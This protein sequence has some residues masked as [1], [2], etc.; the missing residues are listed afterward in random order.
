MIF[1]IIR[2]L[3]V[4]NCFYVF[5]HRLKL[6]FRIYSFLNPIYSCPV[7]DMVL[8]DILP[9][10]VIEEWF[11]QAN[12]LCV[13]EADK[14]LRGFLD[15]FGKDYKFVGSPP[16][17]FCNPFE[18]VDFQ[19]SSK[20]WE[21]FNLFADQ[22]IKLV[23]ESSRWSWAPIFARA[24]RLTGEKKYS[25]GLNRF[26][27]SWCEENPFNSGLNWTCGQEVAIRLLHAMQ[28][29][30]ILDAPKSSP[31]RTKSRKEFVH[32]H[33]KRILVTH[34]YAIAQANNHWL[35]EAAGLFIGG[36]WLNEKKYK[37]LGRNS[38]E[39]CIN[40]LIMK[41]GTFSQYSIN[42]H[43]FVLDTLCL[44]EIWRRILKLDKFSEMFYKNC[45]N[46]VRWLDEFVDPLTGQT[47]NIGA[48]DGTYC[49][50]FHS[51]SYTNFRPTLR[52]A[53]TIFNVE[54]SLKKGIWDEPLFWLNLNQR[55][56][57]KNEKYSIRSDKD[58]KIFPEGGYVKICPNLK[59]WAYLKIPIYKFR[60]IHADPL[61]FDLWSNGKNILRDGG[62][63][64]YNA[65]F[66]DLNYFQGVSSHNTVQFN[67][68]EPMKKIGR[69]LWGDWLSSDFL[70]IQS[71]S[72]S[73]FS[74]QFIIS[75][76]YSCNLGKHIR[77]IEYN[78][79][80]TVW[81]IRDSISNFSGYATLRW[82]LIPA[83]WEQEN[84]QIKSL[85]GSIKINTF[86]NKCSI[87]LKY[88]YES[89]FY[90]YK[91][92]IPV[93][94]VRVKDSPAKIITKFEINKQNN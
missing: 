52:L 87:N 62:S 27:R 65:S 49:Y 72:F 69:F 56:N 94:E 36:S 71:N 39:N 41:D 38:I 46:A 19:N 28:T 79:E 60:P 88:G 3:G 31:I 81:I 16:N 75:S 15:F 35:S 14:Q 78:A 40:N 22:D 2:K 9:F 53:S 25:E 86:E 12:S 89:R 20:H 61:H 21:N 73:N 58:Y 55:L 77:S 84:N 57:I 83:E 13:E 90:F 10:N 26:S 30:Q 70:R 6:R 63:Y 85:Y 18:N 64:K 43:R 7:P 32:I 34:K 92:T 8:D 93:L 80:G 1:G 5:I 29:W 11:K 66:N 50:K 17:W 47:S 23:W 4:K 51:Q 59:N 68:L 33:L 54:I 45:K 67:S 48:N 91:K 82:R 44:I 74:N 24:L 37:S 76:S 42:Y